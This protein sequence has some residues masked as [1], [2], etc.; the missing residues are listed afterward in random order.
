[1]G[2]CGWE[3]M[4]LKRACVVTTRDRRVLPALCVC[5][6]GQAQAGTA[7]QNKGKARETQKDGRP[8]KGNATRKQGPKTTHITNKSNKRP[9]HIFHAIVVRVLCFFSVLVA[10]AALLS[11]ARVACFVGLLRGLCL[12]LRLGAAARDAGPPLKRRPTTRRH[13]HTT[14]SQE[15]RRPSSSYS[16]SIRDGCWS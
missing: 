13:G 7:G 1:M 6:G 10:A 3:R 2:V 14:R 4:E 12:G 9:T 16:S 11:R 8:K 5:K 15:N